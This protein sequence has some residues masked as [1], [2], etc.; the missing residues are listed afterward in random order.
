MEILSNMKLLGITLAFAVVMTGL[1]IAVDHHPGLHSTLGIWLAVPNLPGL[2][3]LNWANYLTPNTAIWDDGPLSWFM[4]GF[5]DWI[6]YVGLAK[7]V[8]V[9]RR[10]FVT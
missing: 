6:T 5:V 3:V 2:A 4:C 1:L 7:A 9:V 8:I 10:K